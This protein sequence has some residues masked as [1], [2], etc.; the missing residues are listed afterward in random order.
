MPIKVPTDFSTASPDELRQVQQDAATAARPLLALGLGTISTEQRA[1]VRELAQF[2]AQATEELAK[3][4][5]DA[6]EFA[7][8]AATF[9]ALEAPAPAAEEPATPA[10]ETTA[11]AETAAPAQPAPAATFAAANGKGGTTTATIPRARD[12]AGAGAQV[13][14]SSVGGGD[15][16]MLTYGELVYD[17]KIGLSEFTGLKQL[18]QAL[19]KRLEGYG[20]PSGSGH[21]TLIEFRRDFPDALRGPGEGMGVSQEHEFGL[22]DNASQA[23]AKL[24]KDQTAAAAYC[25]PSLTLYELCELETT[26][27]ILPMTEVQ[28]SR[29]GIWFTTGPDFA[30]IF[31]GAGYWNY[32]EAQVIANTVKPCMEIPC[33]PFEEQRLRNLGVCITAGILQRRGYPELIARFIRGAMI[34]HLHR[35]NAFV[36]AQMAA[37]STLVD[38]DPIPVGSLVGDSTSSGLLAAAE[39]VA[40]DIRYRNRLAVDAN[41]EAVFPVWA[42]AQLR[43]DVSRRTGVDMISVSDSD[44]VGWFTDRHIT[45]RLVYD[46]QDAYSGVAA[47]PGA[48]LPG[49]TTFPAVVEF[50]IYPPGTWVKG[51][52]DTIRLET[53]YDS[54]KL[55]T[56]QYTALFTEEGVLVAKVCPDSRRVVYPL[57][58]TGA[59]SET[60]A[61]TCA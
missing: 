17:T 30:S 12:I 48:A 46:W 41:L 11:A 40:V 58:P 53:V 4:D 28:I 45:L 24:F 16:A 52:D 34:A 47:G 10:A 26:D 15:G 18:G 54:A 6:A 37:G 56:N 13:D 19:V 59:T 39:M 38:F 51:V 49:I 9:A 32:T 55:S 29:G 20:R 50:M 7:A 60:V 27:G 57:C 1:T 2:A 44:I 14:V 3:R 23:Y 42:L 35:V 61:R 5:A 8:D 31:N 43:A 22:L 33:P 25:A 21:D 36:L